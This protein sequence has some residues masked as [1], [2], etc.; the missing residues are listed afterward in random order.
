MRGLWSKAAGA[1]LAMSLCAGASAQMSLTS[2]VD[3][4]LRSSP[5]VQAAQADVDKAHAALAQ[6]HDAYIPSIVAD[7][8]YGNG[9]GPPS[10]LPTVF[11]LSSQS[12]LFN[13]SQQDNVRAAASGLQAANLT[14]KEVRNQI[15]E[16]V[17]ITYLDLDNAQQRQA[18]MN[19]EYEIATHLVGI[20]QD[21]LAV[22]QDTQLESLRAQRTVL[23]I[24]QEKRHTD[25]EIATLSDHL[26]RLVGLPGTQLTAISVSIPAM[27]AIGTF[28]DNGPDSFGIQSA[29]LNAKSKQ[30]VA[31]GESRYRFRPQLSLGANY[32]YLD[33]S[34]HDFLTYY[35]TFKGKSSNDASVYIQIQVPIFDRAHDDHARESE[36]EAR[37]ARFEAENQR[38]QFLEGRLKLRRSLDE[39]SDSYALAGI[40]RDIAQE[41]LDS[42]LVQLRANAGD[43]NKPQLTPK[44]EQNARLQERQKFI[45]L[46]D[47]QVQLSRAQINLMRQTGQLDGWLKTV[48]SP[49]P[50]AT[51]TPAPR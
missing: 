5:K 15:A 34:E 20:V 1:G 48:P 9:L 40:D 43:P 13:F 45:D 32:S 49:P 35:P 12:L 14:V 33:T 4:A 39:L 28:T 51:L 3:L 25:N 24:R 46:L 37:R 36:A 27:P 17:A 41:Q 42:T 31:F 18:A 6:A 44:D 26:S 23:L 16:D 47:T 30:E 7:G 19:Q 21:R 11:S 38:N 8:G 50:S 22:G 29:F 10:G 2:A